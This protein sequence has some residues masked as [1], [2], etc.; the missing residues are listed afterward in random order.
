MNDIE[1]E[2]KMISAT[3]EWWHNEVST[4]VERL[5]VLNEQQ[6][7]DEEEINEQEKKLRFLYYK[8]ASEVKNV[9]RFFKKWRIDE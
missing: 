9:D 2:A 5:T 4:V 8:G 7:K 1:Q 3:I 6:F